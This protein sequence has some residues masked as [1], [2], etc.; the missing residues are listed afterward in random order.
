MKI[1]LFNPTFLMRRPIAEL[2]KILS[3]DGHQVTVVWPMDKRRSA[4]NQLHFDTL[5]KDNPNIQ[6]LPIW[7][8]EIKSILW[9]FP[10]DLLTLPKLYKIGK[11][12]DLVK[13]WAPFYL[14]PLLPFIMKRLGLFKAKLIGVYDTIPSYSFSMGRITDILFKLFFKLLTKPVLGAANRTA[15]YS[16]LLIPHAVKA[17][18]MKTK[19]AV[20]PT[21]VWIKVKPAEANIREELD[22]PT[23]LPIVLFIGL[24]NKRKG[25]FKVLEVAKRLKERG[26]RF[27]LLMIGK[28]PEEEALKRQI[29]VDKLEDTVRLLGRR[30]DVSNFYHQASCLFLPADGEGL[31]GVVMEAMSYGRAVVSSDIPCI[32]DLVESG[33]SGFLH[34]P[35][36]VAAFTDSLQAIITDKEL[37]K[38]MEKEALRR[39]SEWGWE[40][41]YQQYKHFYQELEI[42]L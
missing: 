29:A 32:P 20:L 38:G 14:S 28:G 1:A 8:K 4:T 17:G 3:D 40:K 27:V 36:D 19:L 35:S 18:F 30:Q 9:S 33:V 21:G 16:E 15:L 26:N 34:D 42:V 11:T 39:I 31:P 5:L 25:V 24:L 6:V 37:R 12:Y 7:S 23:G 2:A 41:R 22:L 10:T 13:V